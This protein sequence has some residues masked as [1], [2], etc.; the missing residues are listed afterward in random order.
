MKKQFIVSKGQ[1]IM[2]KIDAR[3]GAFGVVPNELDGAIVTNDFPSYFVNNKIFK[4]EFLVLMTTTKEFVKFAQSCSSGT[5][6]RQRID[7]ELFLNQKIPLPSLDEQTRIVNS[8]KNKI[9]E[10]EEQE[11]KAKEL[12]HQIKEYLYDI[13]GIKK[14]TT[15]VKEKALLQFISYKNLERWDTNDSI[16]INSNYAIVRLGKCILNISTGTTPPTNRK[17]YFNGKINFYTPSDLSNEMYLSGAERTVTELAIID[18]KARRFD[19]GTL[20]FVGI[21]ST[22]GKVGIVADEFATSNQQITG[23]KINEKLLNIDFLYFYFDTFKEITT[24][25]KTQATIP[26]VNQDKILNIPIPLPSL[27]VQKEIVDNINIMKEKIKTLKQQAGQNRKNAIIEF[28]KIIF[29]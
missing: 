17:E 26:I 10:A 29:K 20:L 8:Y 3:N 5:T 15:I 9:R 24:K 7:I 14:P 13:L 11:K 12:E 1:F 21:G 28:E 6:N 23:L 16:E 25:E 19:K 18:K 27:E 22:I 2:S 4:T